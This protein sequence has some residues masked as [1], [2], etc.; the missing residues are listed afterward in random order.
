MQLWLGLLAGGLRYENV[1]LS[2]DDYETLYSYGPVAVSGGNPA[3]E[4][5]LL[6]AGVIVEPVEGLRAYGSYAEG[7]TIAVLPAAIAPTRGMTVSW[8]G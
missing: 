2:V 1:R 3:F 6:N 7:F 8:K 4:D 5:L